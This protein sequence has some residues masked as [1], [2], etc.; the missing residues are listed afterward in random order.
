MTKLYSPTLY[1][2]QKGRWTVAIFC[3]R[4]DGA[5]VGNIFAIDQIADLQP[6]ADGWDEFETVTI[7]LEPQ[8]EAR[9]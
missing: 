9:Q 4:K 2:K 6:L 7:K 8:R 1:T 3:T 5:E